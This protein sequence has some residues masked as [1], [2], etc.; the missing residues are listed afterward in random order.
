[1]KVQNISVGAL[2]IFGN[3]V[4]PDAVLELTAEQGK[5][6]GIKSLI[7]KG[8]LAEIKEEKREKEPKNPP[9]TE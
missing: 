5:H 7:A 4:A 6:S 9:K 3:V 1:M 8:K 2:V